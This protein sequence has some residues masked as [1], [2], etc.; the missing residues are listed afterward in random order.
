MSKPRLAVQAVLVF[1]LFGIL[2]GFPH[3]GQDVTRLSYVGSALWTKAHDIAL[4]D[5]YAYCAFM[6]GLVILDVHDLKN[7]V[8]LS[9][10]I[11]AEGSRSKSRARS[12]SWPPET[13]ACF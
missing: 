3:S 2:Q 6:N 13:K 11:S 1:L 10:S 9:Q 12:P 4:R 5:R 7:P 8:R